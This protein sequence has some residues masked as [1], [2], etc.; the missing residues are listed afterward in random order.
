MEDSSATSFER[1]ATTPDTRLFN[2]TVAGVSP[3]MINDPQLSAKHF[4]LISPAA[5][6][7]RLRVCQTDA[8]LAV[9]RAESST[10]NGW[11]KGGRVHHLGVGL[12]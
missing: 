2:H 4:G 5:F 7:N 1:H 12:L 6:Q 10:S 3:P 11:I 9:R 8:Q